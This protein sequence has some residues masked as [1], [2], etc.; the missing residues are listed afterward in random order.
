MLGNASVKP[1]LSW[2]SWFYRGVVIIGLLILIGRLIELQ[3]IKGA[4]Y[5]GLADG[6]RARTITIQAPR[7]KI[8]T[9]D[10]H[11]IVTSERVAKTVEFSPIEGYKKIDA[12]EDTPANEVIY[13]YK[14]LYPF[15]HEFAY[16]TGYIAE[17]NKEELGKVDQDCREKGVK[18]LGS[19]IGRS[20]LE[21]TYDCELRGVVGEEIVEVDTR[22]NR[23]RTLGRRNPI[24]GHDITT[25]I[26][27]GLQKK[28]A[29]IMNDQLA[30]VIVSNT[31]G[32]VL[33]LHSS[34]SFDPNL[35][36][37]STGR[38]EDLSSLFTDERLPLFNRVLAGT[39]HPGSLFKIVTSIAGFEAGAIDTDF[40]YVD[41]GSIT[42]D[43]YN[44]TNWY[45]TQYGGTEGEVDT[46][47]ALAR[48]TDTFYYKIG[49]LMGA[50]T[51]TDWARK[52]KLDKK[53][54]ID[55]PG[56]V[57]G[58][59]PSPEWKK[60]VKGERWYLGNTYH[61]SIGQ[62]DLAITPAAIHRV[63]MAMANDGVICDLSLID[64]SNNCEDLGIKKEY[65]AIV[66]E[67]LK[68]ACNPG[69]TAT[70][71]FDLAEPDIACKT[72]TAE[73][74]E[75]DVTHAWF[76]MYTPV[77]DPKYVITVLVEK[78]GGGSDVAAPIAREIVDY[79]YNP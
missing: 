60:A 55:L 70:P 41:T 47:R 20:G 28:V 17:I 37:D 9:Q 13:D 10:G 56:E 50:Q 24:P 32:K 46:I 58:L 44:Y 59:V 6:N 51:I 77:D 63:F 26:D 69:G 38:S 35:F 49:E 14:R 40:E 21:S 67:G 25:T 1:S 71:F 76:S 4:Y 62:G 53:T 15:G 54:N 16:I 31:E 65:M 72:G 34:P 2:L 75:E 8:L 33:A 18:T 79:L 29:E 11:E 43:D 7:G 3:V 23:I 27:F 39:Y 45:F 36:I 22:G 5:R 74:L 61:F 64:D 73:T 48:S 42:V 66:E 19:Y 12:T 78:G 68:Q 52:F 57:L 30:A